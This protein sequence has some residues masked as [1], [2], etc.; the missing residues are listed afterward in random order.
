VQISRHNF[1]LPLSFSTPQESDPISQLAKPMLKIHS[2][3]TLAGFVNSLHIE[4]LFSCD[5]AHL[6]TGACRGSVCHRSVWV[7]GE[8]TADAGF[9]MRCVRELQGD[10][11][12]SLLDFVTSLPTL[13]CYMADYKGSQ[14]QQIMVRLHWWDAWVH[15]LPAELR[16]RILE[17]AFGY[18]VYSHPN[19]NDKRALR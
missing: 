10:C 17:F 15:G 18:D 5:S 4:P 14:L 7:D 9:Y 12:E 6:Y 19:E 13:T 1:Q 16:L 11:I 8:C 2:H 3:S